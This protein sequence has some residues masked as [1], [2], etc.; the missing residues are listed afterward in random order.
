[1]PLLDLGS[2]F[3]RVSDLRMFDLLFFVAGLFV[4]GGRQIIFATDKDRKERGKE[5]NNQMQ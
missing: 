5:R 2:V 4:A 1:V 3:R